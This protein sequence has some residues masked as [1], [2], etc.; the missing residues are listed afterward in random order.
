MP[1]YT[2][3][4]PKTGK[5]I[6]IQQSMTEPHVYVDDSGVEWRRVFYPVTFAFDTQLDGHDAKSF[7]RKTEKGGTLGDIMD[8]SREMSEKRGGEGND[9]VKVKYEK[10]K[11]KKLDDRARSNLKEERQKQFEEF[12]KLDKFKVKVKKKKD[13]L[14]PKSK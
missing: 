8:L 9:E 10:D 5:T 7:V 12:K 3:S 14:G 13:V 4:H 11:Q 2:Y 6:D 1:F